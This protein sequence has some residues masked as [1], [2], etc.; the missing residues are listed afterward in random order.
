MIDLRFK[1]IYVCSVAAGGGMFPFAATIDGREY[2]LDMLLLAWHVNRAVPIGCCRWL[3]IGC[4]L[5]KLV[6][7]KRLT[8]TMADRLFCFLRYPR[9][10]SSSVNS[11][12]VESSTAFSWYHV[13]RGLG[14][15]GQ[16]QIFQI[17]FPYFFFCFWKLYFHNMC[18]RFN[19]MYIS[20]WLLQ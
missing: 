4:H 12:Y 5:V 7:S 19:L 16:K 3:I 8:V 11:W 2:P 14:H 18:V 13:N 10:L 20:I 17:V 1:R 9:K 6:N 15:P